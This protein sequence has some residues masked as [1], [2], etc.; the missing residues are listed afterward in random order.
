MRIKS[1]YYLCVFLLLCIAHSISFAGSQ[2]NTVDGVFSAEKLAPFAKKIEKYAASKGA[3]VFI[4]SRLGS[5]K[6]DLPENIEFTHVGLAVYSE[7]K[8][9][10]GQLLKGYAIHNLYQN[11]QDLSVSNLVI[12]YPMDFF[13]GVAALKAGVIIPKIQLQKKLLAS[14]TTGVNK[15]LHNAN[16]S[17]IAN[18]YSLSYQNCTEH[19]LDILFSSIYETNDH[20]QIKANEKA[21]FKAQKIK[22]SPFKRLLEPMISS[23]I[24]VSDHEGD[25]KTA[26]FSTLAK[27]LNDYDLTQ[28][29]VVIDNLG[30][31]LFDI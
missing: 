19:L 30:V 28:E 29:A 6:S 27:F 12:D 18:P 2:Q 14:I 9:K 5:P 26:T 15:Q 24:S 1:T 25:I 21:Y 16:Y 31:S 7:I 20:A 22:V 10:D 8:A 23:E 17:I 4:I 13:M 3:R 11:A